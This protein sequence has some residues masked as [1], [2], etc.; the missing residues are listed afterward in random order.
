MNTSRW[1]AGATSALIVIGSLNGAPA[2]QADASPASTLYVQSVPWC[3]DTGP[4][5]QD[6][7][8]CRVQA[9]ADVVNPGQ[10]VDILGNASG[11]LTIRRSGT[12]SAPITFQGVSTDIGVADDLA[13]P[14]SVHAP[15]TLSDVHDV[16]ISYLTLDHTSTDAVDVTGSQDVVLDRLFIAQQGPTDAPAETDGVSVDGASSGVTLSRS[17]IYGS[18]GNAVQ[19]ASGAHDITVTTNELVGS[20]LTELAVS[21]TSTA[22]LT[23]NTVDGACGSGITLDGGSSARV[24]NNVFTSTDASS[25][26]PAPTAP[27]FSV[28]ADST[29]TVTADYNAFAPPTSSSRTEYSWSGTEYTSVAGFTSATGQGAHDLD[30]V[31][32][33]YSDATDEN[34]P[35]IDSAD[36]DAPGELATDVHGLPR[37]DDPLVTDSGTGA[38]ATYDRG[39]FERR[40]KMWVPGDEGV[41][42]ASGIGPFDASVVTGDAKEGSWGLPLTYS[43][44]FG[45]GTPAVTNA[46]AT[47][48]HTYTTPGV[49]QA[50]TT[51][52]DANGSYA[53][54][55]TKVTVGT[56]GP[57]STSLNVGRWINDGTVNSGTAVFGFDHSDNWELASRKITYCDNTSDTVPTSSGAWSYTDTYGSLEPCTATLSQTDIFGR[58]ATATVTFRTADSFTPLTPPLWDYHG[59]VKAHSLLTLDSTVLHTD[60]DADNAAALRLTVTGGAAGGYLEAYPYGTTRPTASVLNFAAHQTVSDS[61]TVKT[62]SGAV[63]IY[64]GSS[65]PVTLT[66]HTIARQTH[67]QFGHAYAPMPPARILDTHNGT[68]GVTGPVAGGRSVTV[69]VAGTHGIPSNAAAAV[70]DVETTSTQASGSL[71]VSSHA[72]ANSGVTS[73]Y[74]TKGQTVSNLVVVPLADGKAVLRNNSS[75]SVQFVAD[76]FGYADQTGTGSLFL[77][78]P[79]TRILNTRTGTGTGGHI[80]RL[81]SHQTLK[82]RFAGI[83]GV[84]TTGTTAADLDLT[85][86]SPIAGGFLTAYP[87]GTT[88]PGQASVVFGAERTTTN[89]AVPRVGADGY[90]DIYNGS[91]AAVDIVA[92]QYGSYWRG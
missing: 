51:V 80:A 40:D 8:F 50:R 73:S 10:T 1:A 27:E 64:N 17:Q 59:T 29:G 88:R 35:L 30:D 86:L 68:G 36:A 54:R 26:C 66:V 89:E 70:L 58:T 15:V 45:D 49:Y 11:S 57:P 44:D 4:G 71:T 46:S 6:Q 31:V 14:P 63:Y 77:P 85:A 3:S 52:T 48:T 5:T 74:W 39:A 76:V 56:A 75:S 72:M 22:H 43:V 78:S 91:S 33:A 47:V 79:P 18:H 87:D 90:I 34:S 19:V 2:A 92:D 62:N 84:P 28:T 16:H 42:P 32:H 12:A 60:P 24:E 41:S 61:T 53:T 37:I 38:H 25:D 69:A 23:S 65:E 20:R 83:H 9:A 81:G 21:G 55:V 67:S 13:M 82:L 7:P